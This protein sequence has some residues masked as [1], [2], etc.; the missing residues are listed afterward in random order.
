MRTSRNLVAILSTFVLGLVLAGCET[1]ARVGQHSHGTYWRRLPCTMPAGM[2]AIDTDPAR[3][4][5]WVLTSGTD[6]LFL[7][8]IG[9]DATQPMRTTRLPRPDDGLSELSVS[10]RDGT[11]WLWAGRRVARYVESTR[12]TTAWAL[13]GRAA[14]VARATPIPVTDSQG[15]AYTWSSVRGGVTVT[16]TDPASGVVTSHLFAFRPLLPES[17]DGKAPIGGGLVG[18][19]FVDA[20]VQGLVVDGRDHVVLITGADG[21]AGAYSCAYELVGG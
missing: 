1:P 4:Q 17:T 19:A 14:R 18:P 2:R 8:E 15:R 16:R 10:A 3:H 9:R 6:G 11:V 21:S 5:T 20:R 7:T 12:R 13:P